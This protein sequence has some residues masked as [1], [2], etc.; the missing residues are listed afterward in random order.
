MSDTH[1]EQ[2]GAYKKHKTYTKITHSKQDVVAESQVFLPS[3]Q[4]IARI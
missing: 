2:V 3:L 1:A 4:L